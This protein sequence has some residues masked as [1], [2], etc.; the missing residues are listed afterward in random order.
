[1]GVGKRGEGRELAGEKRREGERGGIGW[2]MG[3]GGGE[4]VGEKEWEREGG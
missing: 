1:M 3:G 2:L 4:N